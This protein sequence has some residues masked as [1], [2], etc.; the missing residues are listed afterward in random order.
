MYRS[1]SAL[2]AGASVQTRETKSLLGARGM[3]HPV[4][5]RAAKPEATSL[6]VDRSVVPQGSTRWKETTDSQK[7][8]PDSG[9]GTHTHTH[10]YTYSALV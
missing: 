6:L 2:G 9:T 10:K 3:V 5:V 7:S 4:K 8:V 1:S